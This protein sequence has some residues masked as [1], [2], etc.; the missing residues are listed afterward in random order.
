MVEILEGVC[1]LL[2]LA[3]VYLWQ[4][5]RSLQDLLQ[6]AEAAAREAVA[7]A[8]EEQ[9]RADLAIDQI[10][11][12]F[13]GGPVSKTGKEQEIEKRREDALKMGEMAELFADEVGST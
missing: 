13:A 2:A 9:R 10:A 5:S 12:M 7:R 1:A 11:R 6:R 4:R 8:Q 3:T